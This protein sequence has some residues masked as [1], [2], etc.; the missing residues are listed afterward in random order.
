MSH[1]LINAGKMRIYCNITPILQKMTKKPKMRTGQKPW[2]NNLHY[3]KPL[4]NAMGKKIL[5]RLIN[6]LWRSPCNKLSIPELYI[7]TFLSLLDN[8]ILFPYHSTLYIEF[9]LYIPWFIFPWQPL[10]DKIGERDH[11]SHQTPS[12][13]GSSGPFY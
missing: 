2:T 6:T 13:S 3:E 7:P 8:R 9:S 5:D 11:G 10:V 1:S 4:T 12:S